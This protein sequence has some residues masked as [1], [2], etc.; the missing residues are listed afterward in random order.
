MHDLP[1]SPPPPSPPRA[2]RRPAVSVLHGQRRVDDYAW[3]RDREDPAVLAY[4]REENLYAEAVTAPLAAL[5]ERLYGEMLGRIQQSDE[6]VPVRRGRYETFWRT[7]EGQQYPAFLRR[8]VGGGPEEILLDENELAAGGDYLAI[9]D[10]E[11]SPDARFL[12]YT[13]DRSG[14]ERFT[15]RLRDLERRVDLEETIPDVYYSLVWSSDSTT[16]FY[17]RTDAAHRPDRVFRHR[18]GDDPAGDA[19]V[20]AEPDELFRLAVGRTKDHL[21][22]TLTAQ[23]FEQAEVWWIPAARP[24]A[25]P[26]RIAPRRPGVLYRIEHRDGRLLLL[27]ND[28]APD[29]RLVERPWEGGPERELVPHVPGRLLAELEVF[30]DF[31]LLLEREDG[32]P[33][34]RL[35]DFAGGRSRRIDFPDPVYALALVETPEF[36]GS[37][38]RL[39]YGSPVTPNSIFDLDGVSGALTLRKRQ[40]VLGGY[41]PRRYRCERVW[42]RAADGARVPISLHGREPLARDG[43]RPV[44]LLAYGAYG[45]SYD[46]RFSSRLLSLVDRGVTIA[47]AHVRGGQEMGRAWYEAGRLGAKPNSFTDTIACAEHLVASGIAAPDRLALRGGS[48]GGLLVGAVLNLRPDLFRVAVADVPFVDVVNTMLDASLPLTASE[49]EQW[50]DPRRPEDFALLASYSPYENVARQAYPALL[51]TA[52]LNDPRVAFWEPAKWVAKLR[53]TKTDREPLLLVTHLGSGHAGASGRYDA[54]REEAFTYAF[55]LDRLGLAGA[56]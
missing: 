26:R 37:A 1:P 52:G 24:L 2:E 28:G 10:A 45:Y 51:V 25:E 13:V 44:L 23:S 48:A 11:I 54:L 16:L 21:Y 56:S 17:T 39:E 50:G 30:R 43:S 46:A 47:I 20:L 49:W 38:A 19:L 40:P 3:L 31:A 27:T 32:L 22:V 8:P 42:A 14:G 15:L 41:D 33:H 12:A 34:V 35:L 36:T 6:T 5:R 55:L 9:G 29:F 18:L 53:A 4:L 7:R